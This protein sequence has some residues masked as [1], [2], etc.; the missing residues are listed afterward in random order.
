[1]KTIGESIEICHWNSNK[2]FHVW[3]HGD[4]LFKKKIKG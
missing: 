1:L 2:T 3:K 4:A